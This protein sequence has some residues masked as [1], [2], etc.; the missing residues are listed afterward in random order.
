MLDDYC[1]EHSENYYYLDVYSGVSFTEKIYRKVDNKKK[2]YDLLGGWICNSPLQLEARQEYLKGNEQTD[3]V[4]EQ[5]KTDNIQT[6]LLRD[7]FYFVIEAIGDTAFLTD[8]YESRGTEVVLEAVDCIG[9]E[10]N[11]FWIYHL[12]KKNKK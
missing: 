6:A 12:E 5:G 2:N 7:N 4:E 1:K 11:P 10:E 9:E 8:Y 3:L